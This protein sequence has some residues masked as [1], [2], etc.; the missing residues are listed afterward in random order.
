VAQAL[1]PVPVQL[2]CL[3]VVPVVVAVVAAQWVKTVALVVAE[4]LPQMTAAR[5]SLRKDSKVAGA[6]VT[7]FPQQ[8][9]VLV[10]VLA[11]Q[12]NSLLMGLRPLLGAQVFLRPLPGRRLHAQVGAGEYP[13]SS[14]LGPLVALVV[15]ALVV[16]TVQPER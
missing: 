13:C 8:P 12:G 6:T 4:H 14:L 10:G 9:E 5:V 2:L 3:L 16:R 11:R 15:A 1:L 7:G